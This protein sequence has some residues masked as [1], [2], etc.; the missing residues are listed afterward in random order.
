MNKKNRFEGLVKVVIFVAT[1]VG[2]LFFI[3]GVVMHLNDVDDNTRR[4]LNEEN[5][6][7]SQQIFYGN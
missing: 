7:I 3:V 1:F 2:V 4:V 6:T 5:A